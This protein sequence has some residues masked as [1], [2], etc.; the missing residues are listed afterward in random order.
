MF[1]WAGSK[2]GNKWKA[3]VQS[4]LRCMR[5]PQTQNA[6]MDTLR[7]KR[8]GSKKNL[9]RMSHIRL[10]IQGLDSLALMILFNRCIHNC[11]I[12]SDGFYYDFAYKPT[13]ISTLTVSPMAPIT[14]ATFAKA[15][16]TFQPSYLFEARQVPARTN[17]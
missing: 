4:W 5:I 1:L 14:T 16:Q 13:I 3:L 7:E 2:L 9:T 8:C 17:V 10:R 6:V 12:L 11:T 15:A